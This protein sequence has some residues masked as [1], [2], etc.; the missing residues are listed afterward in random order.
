MGCLCAEGKWWGHSD[1]VGRVRGRL[2]YQL[3]M[4]LFERRSMHCGQD[5]KSSGGHTFCTV[6]VLVT[7]TRHHVS[8]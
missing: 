4:Y 7:Y 6:P 1:L 3:I 2:Y 5:N 8:V